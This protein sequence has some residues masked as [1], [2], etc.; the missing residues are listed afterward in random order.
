MHTIFA[1]KG[2][3]TIEL[4]TLYGYTSMT[5]ALTTDSRQGLHG[6]LDVREYWKPGGH[7][8]VDQ[9]LVDRILSAVRIALVMNT[10]T[11]SPI[12]QVKMLDRKG[13][14]LSGPSE[15]TVEMNDFF[16]P[17]ITAQSREC[18]RMIFKVVRD[19]I[20]STDNDH[21]DE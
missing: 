14:F 16:G 3:I 7:K 4:K 21:C 13:D 9:P 6:Q 20:G 10:S 19:L 12:S 17:R 11:E 15:V 5:F 8:P 2:V 1:P 18:S